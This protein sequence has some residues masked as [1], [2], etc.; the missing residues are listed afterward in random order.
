MVEYLSAQ[1]ARIFADEERAVEYLMDLHL[2]QDQKVDKRLKRYGITD[3]DTGEQRSIKEVAAK[4]EAVFF[5]SRNTSIQAID[6]Q[7]GLR[8]SAN[9]DQDLE[10]LKGGVYRRGKIQERIL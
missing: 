6:L 7:R 2:E 4:Y 1:D 9:S 8:T 3:P 5:Q 10:K